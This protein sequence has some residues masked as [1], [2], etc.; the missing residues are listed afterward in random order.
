MVWVAWV[1]GLWIV[2]WL[3]FVSFGSFVLVGFCLFLGLFLSVLFCWF[4]FD[5]LLVVCLML[6][7]SG[8]DLVCFG[9]WYL[10]TCVGLFL[11]FVVSGCCCFYFCS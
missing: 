8:L 1:L 6:G 9:W 3:G 10:Y 11:C 4:V 5:W 7:F 2:L